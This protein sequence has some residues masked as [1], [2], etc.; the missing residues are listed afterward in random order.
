MPNDGVA[1]DMVTQT[2]VM[3]EDADFVGLKSSSLPPK[4][5]GEARL[6]HAAPCSTKN[7]Q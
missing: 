4:L 5:T 1:G 2:D 6:S 3:G 7:P